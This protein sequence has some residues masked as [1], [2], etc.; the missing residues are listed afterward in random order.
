MFSC[1]SQINNNNDNNNNDN[2]NKSNDNK[3]AT[4]RDLNK[5]LI[6]LDSMEN[7]NAKYILAINLEPFSN[8]NS[9]INTMVT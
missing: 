3:C 5:R 8:E 2:N 9:A 6:R 1:V 7:E 4:V